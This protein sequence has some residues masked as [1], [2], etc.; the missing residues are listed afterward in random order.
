MHI[1]QNVTT[2]NILLIF[3]LTF[4]RKVKI[5][6]SLSK[7]SRI[8]HAVTDKVLHLRILLMFVVRILFF[9]NVLCNVV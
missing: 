5:K 3:L 1:F 7:N 9:D 2:Q 8:Y 4:F 6:M